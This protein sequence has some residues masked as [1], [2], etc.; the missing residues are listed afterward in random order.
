M[1]A[2]PL[3]YF[4]LTKSNVQWRAAVDTGGSYHDVFWLGRAAEHGWIGRNATDW[5]T[6]SKIYGLATASHSTTLDSSVSAGCWCHN[7]LSTD[8]ILLLLEL[9][10]HRTKAFNVFHTSSIDVLINAGLV[11]IHSNCLWYQPTDEPVVILQQD[12]RQHLHIKK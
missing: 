11:T 7:W 3:L 12:V 9:H 8:I 10:L 2:S 4:L 1:C 5:R 6:P